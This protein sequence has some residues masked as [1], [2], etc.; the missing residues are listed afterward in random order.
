MVKINPNLAKLKQGYLFPEIQKRKVAFLQKN[1]TAKLISLGIGDTTRPV[2]PSVAKSLEEASQALGTREGYSGYGSDQGRLKL[3]EMIASRLYKN[4]VSPDELFISDGAKCDCGR[5][6]LLFDENTTVAV[7]DPT[8]PVYVDTT[9]ISG[10]KPTIITMPCN[11]ENNFFPEPVKADFI[12][13]CS[14]NNPTGSVA[15]REQL[16]KF[17][18]F[19]K[20]NKAIILFDSAYSHFIQDADLPRSIYEIEGADEVA[21]EIGSF[22]K[23][24]GF[25]G[26][27]LGWSIIPKK[28]Q[29]EAGQSVHA[30]WSRIM[31][32]FF[33]G[34][35][36]I[37][38]EGGIAALEDLGLAEIEEVIAYYMENAHIIKETFESLGYPCYGGEH[39]PYVWVDYSPKTSWEA[40]DELL[41]H[42]HVVAIPGGGFGP[43]GNRFIRF[44]AFA[45]REEILEAMARIS[46]LCCNRS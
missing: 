25:T 24:A 26:I 18:L 43:S 3:R 7:Q 35:S 13:L 12:Y 29:F 30:A 4:L 37:A 6:Q 11:P 9:V 2:V 44:S 28:L 36:N 14:P 16:T 17:V 33:N 46:H 20:E 10:K 19:A 15:T 39:A 21:I 8:Y 38:Q 5:L 40:F 22:S 32:T 1:P 31:S 23:L 42:S 45:S 41:H 34:A 27:R